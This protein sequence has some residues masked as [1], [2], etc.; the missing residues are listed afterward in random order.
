MMYLN[1]DPG[2]TTWNCAQILFPSQSRVRN[3]KNSVIKI[4]MG[5]VPSFKAW[6]YAQIYLCH[7][8][9]IP[10]FQ[11]LTLNCYFEIHILTLDVETINQ[12][13]AVCH[14]LAHNGNQS[15]TNLETFFFSQSPIQVLYN[16]EV[17]YL[18]A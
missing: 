14:D 16:L 18:V 2:F 11:T 5:I 17:R 10:L 9:F 15:N 7:S 8:D 3:K 12:I 1:V 13:K 6:N 4:C